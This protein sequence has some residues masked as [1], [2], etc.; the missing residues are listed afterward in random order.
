VLRESDEAVLVIDQWAYL[1]IARSEDE[2]ASLLESRGERQ[3]DRDTYR[4]LQ[5][6][7][8]QLQP[9]HTGAAGEG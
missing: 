9:I 5:K 6:V 1:G 4:I 2:L 7:A 8:R 3:F